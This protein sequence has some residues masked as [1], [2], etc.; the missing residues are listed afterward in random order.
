MN[1]VI[2][3]F[4][5][6][7]GGCRAGCVIII[8]RGFWRLVS[9]PPKHAMGIWRFR[10]RG[11]LC[12][13]VPIEGGDDGLVVVVVRNQTTGKLHRGGKL[14]A[15]CDDDGSEWAKVCKYLPECHSEKSE[16]RS[17]AQFRE[18]CLQLALH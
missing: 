5:A 9:T 7:G 14:G 11:R 3:S 18:M 13:V 17:R 8:Y 10:Q 15:C 2:I 1:N 4:F 6:R 12:S 16:L